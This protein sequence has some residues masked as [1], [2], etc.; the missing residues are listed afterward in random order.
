MFVQVVNALLLGFLAFMVANYTLHQFFKNSK[1][2]I[3]TAAVFAVVVCFARSFV[4]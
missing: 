2:V 1:A 3:F 4:L